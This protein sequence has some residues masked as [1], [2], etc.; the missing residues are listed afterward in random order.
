MKTEKLKKNK[1]ITLTA[2][3][4]TIVVLLILAG[5]TI[6][7]L[8]G[9]NG[10]IKKVNEVSERTEKA[11]EEELKKLIALEASS[12]LE[13]Q[14]YIDKNGDKAI[15]PAGYAVSQVDGENIINDGLVIIDSDEN[16]FVWI[17]IDKAT[18]NVK[19]TNKP[20]AKVTTKKNGT[21]NYQGVLYDFFKTEN[22]VI[23]QE[24]INYGQ[25][26]TS[27]REP[28]YLINTNYGD[29]VTNDDTKGTA[30]LRK[31]IVE[32]RNETDD[33][34]L[35]AWENQLQ[36][37]YNSMIESVKKYGGFYV[38]RYEMGEKNNKPVSKAGI[39]PTSS[40]DEVTLTWY[41]LYAMAKKYNNNSVQA[42]MI[43]GSQY[44]S[45]LNWGLEGKDKLKIAETENGNHSNIF[46]NTGMYSKDKIN[47]IYDLEGNFWEWTLEA[48]TENVRIL[49]GGHYRGSFSPSDR[50]MN[51]PYT[52][53]D[54]RTTRITLYVK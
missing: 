37:E 31:Y 4:I 25:G 8:T 36:N 18:L 9:D 1:G 44:D 3:V 16:E 45:M 21:N 46:V 34:I 15:I 38:G 28:A 52:T 24:K 50:N 43:W 48:N 39:M 22:D 20:I 5:V 49:R 6:A 26:T 53:Y 30:L 29:A 41:G 27:Y 54:N 35:I 13:N 33:T 17:P 47:N 14:E 10:I 19:G 23:S 42:S 7:T 12:N 2:L 32:L 40:G 51:S 11:K